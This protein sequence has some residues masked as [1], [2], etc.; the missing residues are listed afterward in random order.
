MLKI[1][2]SCKYIPAEHSAC[3]FGDHTTTFKLAQP[4]KL[5]FKIS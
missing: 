5:L 1:S 2:E 4:T 3:V